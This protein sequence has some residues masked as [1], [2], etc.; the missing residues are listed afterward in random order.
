MAAGFSPIESG[1]DDRSSRWADPEL[2]FWK[3]T[4]EATRA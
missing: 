1:H 3:K 2:F 4:A